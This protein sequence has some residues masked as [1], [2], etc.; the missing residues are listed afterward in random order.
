MR[1]PVEN[2]TA[3]INHHGIPHLTTV[4]CSNNSAVTM[5]TSN[6]DPSCSEDRTIRVF[7][8]S[9]LTSMRKSQ[10][11]APVQFNQCRVL[12]LDFVLKAA[13]LIHF[14]TKQADEKIHLAV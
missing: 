2:E 3:Y 5:A 10:N 14:V 12:V 11:E 9:F 8:Y 4:D 1:P 7:N 13:N 6:N